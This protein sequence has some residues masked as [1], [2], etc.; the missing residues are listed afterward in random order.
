MEKRDFQLVRA[1]SGT[2]KGK[3]F[4]Q[5]NTSGKYGFALVGRNGDVSE[6]GLDYANITWQFSRREKPRWA[7]EIIR[8]IEQEDVLNSGRELGEG[9]EK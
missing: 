9:E 1:V 3:Y 5:M 8:E 4:L 6:G 2:R 7:K